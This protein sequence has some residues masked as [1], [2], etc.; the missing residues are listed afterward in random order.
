MIDTGAEISI[1]HESILREGNIPIN[2]SPRSIYSVT[3]DKLPIIGETDVSMQVG[4]K[5]YNFSFL[6]G[7]DSLDMGVGGILGYD[8]FSHFRFSIDGTNKYLVDGE[9]RIPYG[10]CSIP[11]YPP[12]IITNLH[13]H[14]TQ[15]LQAT[16]TTPLIKFSRPSFK[17]TEVEG[18]VSIVRTN[19]PIVHC[20]AQDHNIA[21]KL[22]D[23]L[24]QKQ[25][26]QVV[27]L[28][29]KKRCHFYLITRGQEN[30][31]VHLED[32]IESFQALRRFCLKLQITN[33]AMPLFNYPHDGLSWDK[34]RKNLESVFQNTDIHITVFSQNVKTTSKDC[35]TSNN[36]RTVGTQTSEMKRVTNLTQSTKQDCKRTSIND[37]KTVSRH[38][39]SCQ[40]SPQDIQQDAISNIGSLQTNNKQVSEEVDQLDW[41]QSNSLTE[42]LEITRTSKPQAKAKLA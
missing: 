19:T 32:L 16:G 3:G 15:V 10:N 22:S 5:I 39:V 27:K 18:N 17:L 13:Q 29:K 2:Y 4:N 26:G 37:N 23:R 11:V 35:L 33:L 36:H 24:R 41:A 12:E 38:A 34:I 6:V 14:C 31:K 21:K 30:D 7:S 20:I 8:W 25:V 40:T 9:N 42:Y 28:R 1:L